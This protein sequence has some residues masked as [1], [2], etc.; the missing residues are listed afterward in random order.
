MANIASINV[1]DKVEYRVTEGRG[2][3]RKGVV[4]EKG[5]RKLSVFHNASGVV[6]LSS[7]DIIGLDKLKKSSRK[8]LSIKSKTDDS[9]TSQK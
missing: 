7:D 2:R 5:K 6:K 8:I 9:S 3:A 4:V 1:G